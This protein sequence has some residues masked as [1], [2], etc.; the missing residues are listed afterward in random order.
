MGEK[1]FP[2]NLDSGDKFLLELILK[3]GPVVEKFG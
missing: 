1:K 3:G 2:D